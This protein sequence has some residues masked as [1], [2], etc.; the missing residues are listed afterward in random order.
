MNFYS[1]YFQS[2]WLL[3]LMF[4]MGMNCSTSK[5]EQQQSETALDPLE[6]LEEVVEP[7]PMVELV[8]EKVFLLCRQEGNT[9]E[10]KR[11]RENNFEL[12]LTRK[13]GDDQVE[14]GFTA[15]A[16]EKQELIPDL[17]VRNSSWTQYI[18]KSGDSFS[19]IQTTDVDL[20]GSEF[21]RAEISIDQE[22]G[23]T[24]SY[25]FDKVESV[26]FDGYGWYSMTCQSVAAG[27]IS[28]HTTD[29]VQRD[30]V[31]FFSSIGFLEGMSSITFN[32]GDDGESVVFYCWEFEKLSDSY[33]NKFETETFPTFKLKPEFKD[34]PFSISWVSNSEVGECLLTMEPATSN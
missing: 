29:E 33:F 25:Q 34:K 8:E 21:S 32:S 2:G 31:Y 11:N 12:L 17:P 18:L 5:K 7:E 27:K 3:V 30:G 4:G 24:I 26:D 20:V 6:K 1:R 28:L 19:I 14:Y 22:D 23:A 16:C 9:L 13:V 10:I 15:K